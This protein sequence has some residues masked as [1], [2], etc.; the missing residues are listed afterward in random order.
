LA[1][2][3]NVEVTVLRSTVAA[4]AA[5]VIAIPAGRASSAATPS[6]RAIFFISAP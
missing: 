2:A 1:D 6:A 3:K 4:E 5:E